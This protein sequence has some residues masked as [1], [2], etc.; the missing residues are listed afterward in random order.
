M[1]SLHSTRYSRPPKRRW[2]VIQSL[3][4]IFVFSLAIFF[5]L[6]SPVFRVKE[7]RVQGNN[8]LS[9]EQILALAGLEK[10]VNIFKANLAQAQSKLALN[11]IVKQVT[12]SRHFPATI[13]ID[14]TERKAIGLMANPGHFIAVGEDGYCLALVN[15]LASINL[16]IITGAKPTNAMPGQS[17]GDE[18][19]KAAL[20][21]LIA[22]PLNMR[23]SVS[24]INASDLNNI[25]M[26]SI[27]ETEV[28]FGDVNRITEKVKLYQEVTR[29]KF[30]NK[31]Q[32][33]DISFKGDPVIKFIE[34]Q[35]N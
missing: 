3:F 6:Q 31:I 32:Y 2:H 18:R 30:N 21:Y 33:I 16:P 11:P 10:G 22:M 19:L 15:N 34:P 13:V 1:P 23:A 20:A 24:E 5:F 4:F 25:R 12:I 29:Q 9:R 26:F 7:V 8:Q 14:L 28:R 35:S 27:D 17:I